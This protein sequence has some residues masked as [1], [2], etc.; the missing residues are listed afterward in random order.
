MDSEEER[1]EQEAMEEILT[2][3]DQLPVLNYRSPDEAV[4]YD[5][6]GLPTSKQRSM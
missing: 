3:V 1:K 4:G 6:H 2:R 5:D